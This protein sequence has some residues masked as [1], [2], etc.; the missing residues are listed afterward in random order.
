MAVV[1]KVCQ[2]TITVNLVHNF[3]VTPY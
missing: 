2:V 1:M 3:Y